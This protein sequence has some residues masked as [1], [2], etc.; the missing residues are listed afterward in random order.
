M[1]DIAQ[2]LGFLCQQTNYNLLS[3]C[4]NCIVAN[5]ESPGILSVPS[6]DSYLSACEEL[7]AEG[8]GDPL[9]R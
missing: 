5:G 2:C 6:S 4:L 1:N 7:A 8:I 3:A 9:S